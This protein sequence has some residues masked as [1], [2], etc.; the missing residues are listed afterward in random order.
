MDKVNNIISE[1]KLLCGKM[2]NARSFLSSA[3]N[4]I[5]LDGDKLEEKVKEGCANIVKFK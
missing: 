4:I 2:E 3:E 5:K 1:L